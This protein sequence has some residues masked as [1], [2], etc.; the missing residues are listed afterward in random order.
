MQEAGI[1][2][3]APVTGR[4]HAIWHARR[5]QDAGVPHPDIPDLIRTQNGAVLTHNPQVYVWKWPPHTS[6]T[7]D[8]FAGRGPGGQAGAG[9]PLG[10]ELVGIWGAVQ[11]Q[12][13]PQ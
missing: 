4:R 12:R 8:E 7:L 13:R 9:R 3:S 10:H 5:R 11:H 6:G 1:I 2:H